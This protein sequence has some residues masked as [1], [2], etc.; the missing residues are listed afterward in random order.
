M[1]YLASSSY[2]PLARSGFFL[3]QPRQ[4]MPL[5]EKTFGLDLVP[6]IS[7]ALFFGGGKVG[8]APQCR[9]EKE[10]SYIPSPIHS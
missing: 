9:E 5:D 3:L 7:A 10:E 4:K 1:I 2:F 6:A 8:V